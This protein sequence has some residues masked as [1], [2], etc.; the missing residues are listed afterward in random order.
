[1]H[2]S[3]AGGDKYKR[4]LARQEWY[5]LRLLVRL[6]GRIMPLG[7][8]SSKVRNVAKIAVTHGVVRSDADY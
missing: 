4:I 1:M 8:D 6:E 2:L 7:G 3:Q 5:L